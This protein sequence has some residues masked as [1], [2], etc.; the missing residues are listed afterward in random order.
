LNDGVL[1]GEPPNVWYIRDTTGDG[2]GDSRELVYEE[3]GDPN[4]T[5]VESLPNGLMWGM[6]NWLHNVDIGAAALRQIDGAVAC[7]RPFERLGQWGVTQ[8]DWGHIYSASN[9]RPLLDSLTV[10]FSYSHRHP[11]FDLSEGMN[12]SDCTQ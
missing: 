8:D 7:K 6:D 9:P 2:K 1:I 3:Y 11:L 12:E 10:P 4:V 5:N